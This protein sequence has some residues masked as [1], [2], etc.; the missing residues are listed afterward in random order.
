MFERMRR[1]DG[2]CIDADPR[3]LFFFHIAKTGGTSITAAIGMRYPRRLVRSERGN[4]SLDYADRLVAEGLA[5]GWFVHG[6]P[7]H[8]VGALLRGRTRM[9]TMLRD[10]VDQCVSN[11]LFIRGD[12]A[13]PNQP[14]AK[15]MGFSAFLRAHPYYAI[16]Q[17]GSLLVG[18]LPEL[19][20]IERFG[21]QLPAIK[22]FLNDMALVGTSRDSGRF[23]ED[24][25]A[26]MGWDRPP[27]AKR[28]RRA[29]AD[30]REIESLR[31]ERLAL[32]TDDRLAPLFAVERTVFALACAR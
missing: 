10:P 13:N 16:F 29:K 23:L 15:A 30:A 32:E 3:P 12:P 31:A 20:P 21:D 1:R 4:L 11:Y 24:L 14:A 9:V 22:A 28:L 25:S 19:P 2:T 27:V 6:H 7:A 17:T 26:L 8:G 18:M 5:P